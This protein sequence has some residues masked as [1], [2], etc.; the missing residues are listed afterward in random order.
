MRTLEEVLVDGAPVLLGNDHAGRVRLKWSVATCERQLQ[1]SNADFL[2]VL[3]AIVVR[4]SPAAGTH[5]ISAYLL[6]KL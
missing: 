4:T 3:T 6:T 5:I 2:N 1:L